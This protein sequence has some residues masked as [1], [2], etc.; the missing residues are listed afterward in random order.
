MIIDG[1]ISH[2]VKL[3]KYSNCPALFS[4]QKKSKT[5]LTKKN[6]QNTNSKRRNKLMNTFVKTFFFI[7]FPKAPQCG[8]PHNNGLNGGAA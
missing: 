5:L 7:S 8:R 4:S 3:Q 1:I 6:S 2:G